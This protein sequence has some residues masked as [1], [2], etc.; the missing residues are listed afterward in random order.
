MTRFEDQAA[1]ILTQIDFTPSKI[2]RIIHGDSL[3]SLVFRVWDL[4]NKSFILKFSY[5]SD[6]WRKEKYYLTLLQGK[7]PVPKIANVIPPQKEFS[8]GIL[9]EDI[10]GEL[11]KGPTL[12]NEWACKMGEVLGKLHSIPT[13]T[14]A[15]LSLE[16]NP[17]NEKMTP[18]KAMQSYFDRSLAE[19]ETLVTSNLLKLC[20][21]FVDEH[22]HLLKDVDGPCIVHRDYRPGNV[23]ASDGKIQAVIDFENTMG[24]FAEEDFLQ[25]DLLVWGKY[26]S[27]RISFLQGYETIRPLPHLEEL[28][29]LLRLL[30]SLGAIGFTFERGTWESKHK[31]VYLENLSYLKNFFKSY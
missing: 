23:I 4:S 7:I 3:S 16:E 6:R 18:M 17:E 14:Y 5:N 29:P 25:M 13:Q 31:H 11:L 12:T 24:S 8:G 2:E 19:C 15:D 27:T 20:I 1:A 26:P 28:L 22:L 30:K 9:M 21:Q 10:K